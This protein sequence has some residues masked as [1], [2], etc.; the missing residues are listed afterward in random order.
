MKRNSDRFYEVSLNFQNQ[1]K[2]TVDKFE[3]R[4]RELEKAK[5]SKYFD[6]QS[7]AAIEEKNSK[8]KALQSSYQ[9]QV[10][11]IFADMRKVNNSR[12]MQ[13]P[14]EQQLAIL[15]GLKLREHLSYDDIITAANSL[16]DNRFCLSVLNEIAHKNNVIGCNV[17]SFAK[18]DSFTIG[19]VEN[20]ISNAEKS[21]K[22]FVEY[23]TADSVRR[24][25]SQRAEH[26]G[27]SYTL[28]K[29]PLFESKEQCFISLCGLSE[30]N[31]MDF[32]FA[33]D[34]HEHA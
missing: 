31:W 11:D 20:I 28:P 4:M 24:I 5:G 27:N 30:S 12:K 19:E 15:N 25:A 32:E 13:P 2:L 1:R 9:A 10:K 33:I 16:C 18:S 23:D 14:T 6:E 17:M 8:L 21:I 7:Q 34:E 22:D 3:S 26:Y 29:R